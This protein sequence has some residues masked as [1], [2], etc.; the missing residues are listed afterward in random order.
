MRLKILFGKRTESPLKRRLSQ[1]CKI[2]NLADACKTEH[3]YMCMYNSPPKRSGYIH[4]PTLGGGSP[5]T[6]V[7]SPCLLSEYSVIVC[8]F[9]F[10]TLQN[11]TTLGNKISRALCMRATV[12]N[13]NIDPKATIKPKK[14]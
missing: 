1:T 2:Q 11:I 12:Q 8:R 13:N 9:I 4:Y 5:A 14:S 7:L 3:I 6:W 10:T